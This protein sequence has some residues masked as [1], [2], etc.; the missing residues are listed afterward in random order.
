MQQYRLHIEPYLTCIVLSGALAQVEMRHE[1]ATSSDSFQTDKTSI[2]RPSIVSSL[3]VSNL[4]D[5]LASSFT[6]VVGV[7]SEAYRTVILKIWYT[8]I[9]YLIRDCCV[10]FESELLGKDA[11]KSDFSRKLLDY[12]RGYHL[13]F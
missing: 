13:G 1:H 8:K 2:S 5:H 3:E 7:D 4:S 12:W 9:L 10:V 6:L 11:Q